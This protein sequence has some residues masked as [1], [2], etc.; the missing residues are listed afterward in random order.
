[1]N[2]FVEVPDDI[3]EKLTLLTSYCGQVEVIRLVANLGVDINIRDTNNTAL[4]LTAES[5]SVDI[6]KILIDKGVSEDPVYTAH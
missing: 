3:H 4:H 1:V 5:G 2:L 6:I